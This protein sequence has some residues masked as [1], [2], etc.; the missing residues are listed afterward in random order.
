VI[1][2]AGHE[3][4]NG[5]IGREVGSQVGGN[6]KLLFLDQQDVRGIKPDRDAIPLFIFWI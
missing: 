4:A 6:A 5:A 2:G 3:R 1:L